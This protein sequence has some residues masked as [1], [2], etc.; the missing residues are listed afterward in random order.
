MLIPLLIMAVAFKL[1]YILV[2]L[3]R[4]RV[5]VLQRERNARWVRDLVGGAP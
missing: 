5:E 3:M 4:A 1:F 2:L